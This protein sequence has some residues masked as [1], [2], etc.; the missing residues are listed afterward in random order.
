MGVNAKLLFNFGPPLDW[1][2]A[3]IHGMTQCATFVKLHFTTDPENDMKSTQRKQKL[4]FTK[5]GI[6]KQF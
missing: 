3:T 5:Y 2:I 6:Q 1:H 4:E